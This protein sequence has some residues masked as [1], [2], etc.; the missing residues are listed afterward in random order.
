[1]SDV[2]SCGAAVA[3]DPLGD[4]EEALQRGSVERVDIVDGLRVDHSERCVGIGEHVA[5]AIILF[6][7]LVIRAVGERGPDTAE[8]VDE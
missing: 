8:V 1:M 5:V 3:G 7:T 6:L 2:D 4:L